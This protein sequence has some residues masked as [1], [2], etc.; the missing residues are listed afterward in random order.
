MIITI[1]RGGGSSG[2][3]A[4]VAEAAMTAVTSSRYHSAGEITRFAD[5]VTARWPCFV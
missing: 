2:E 3:M 4:A 1:A 5:D